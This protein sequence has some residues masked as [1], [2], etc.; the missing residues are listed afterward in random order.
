MDPTTDVAFHLRK[1]LFEQ[2]K[3]IDICLYLKLDMQAMQLVYSGIDIA[4][5][6][7]AE[8]GKASRGSFIKW[9]DSYMLRGMPAPFTAIELYGA[10]CGLL[11]TMTAESD[12]SRSKGVRMVLYANEGADPEVLEA[13]ID[14]H[15][16]E[17]YALTRTSELSNL[18][19][20]GLA[21]Y[22]DEVRANPDRVLTVN[23][24]A[25]TRFGFFAEDD[26]REMLA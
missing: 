2:L 4:G 24:N 20:A 26:I 13:L 6:L 11:H 19:R 25:K 18:F 17:K 1:F 3:A 8:D 9:A 5:S 10:R 12:L 22:L 23:E 7:E 15:D 21:S 14:S 16:P